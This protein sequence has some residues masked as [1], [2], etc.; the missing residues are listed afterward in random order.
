MGIVGVV[1]FSIALFVI[2]FYKNYNYFK[3]IFSIILLIPLITDD[4]FERQHGVFIFVALY[5]LNNF[6]YEYDKHKTS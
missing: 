1:C 4:T 2:L 6:L 5:L 3:I